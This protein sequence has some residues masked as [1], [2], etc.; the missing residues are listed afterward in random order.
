[1]ECV[2]DEALTTDQ[3]LLKGARARASVAR[4]AADVASVEGLTGLS[5]GRIATDLGLS[6]SGVA[7]LFGSKEKLQ[8]AA[9]RK[10]REV[11]I[12]RI[13]RP[14]V[15]AAEGLPRLRELI[16]RWYVYASEPAFSGGCFQAAA[17][18]EFDSRPG[19]VRDAIVKN[20]RDWLALLAYQVR[21]AQDAGDFDTGLDA[22]AVAFQIDAILVATNTG[23]RLGD[24]SA[25][26]TSRAILYRLLSGCPG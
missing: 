6:K 23:L 21:T 18:V 8:I 11:F 5:I 19:S 7:G 26:P 15:D 13:V 1:M 14:S 3:R 17:L 4:H 20:H 10:A 25:V 24:A 9:V 22:D 12:D 2:T 16:D